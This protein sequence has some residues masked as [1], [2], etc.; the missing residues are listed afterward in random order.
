[1]LTDVQQQWLLK[2]MILG[3]DD[4]AADVTFWGRCH[5]TRGPHA[6]MLLGKSSCTV[7]PGL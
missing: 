3:A 1:M 6:T 7:V 2:A 4:Q 5:H